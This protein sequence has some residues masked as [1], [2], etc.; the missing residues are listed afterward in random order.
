I[1][2]A[3][4]FSEAELQVAFFRPAA[5]GGG[6]SESGRRDI[7]TVQDNHLPLTAIISARHNTCK[8]VGKRTHLTDP[9][10]AVMI[11]QDCAEF[12]V[13]LPPVYRAHLEV[14]S[15][16]MVFEPMNIASLVAHAIRFGQGPYFD[17]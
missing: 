5:S 9:D 7:K 13:P 3:K 12:N 14:N 6:W 10:I 17:S 11:V 8:S 1:Y 15:K 16:H 2:E 4:G